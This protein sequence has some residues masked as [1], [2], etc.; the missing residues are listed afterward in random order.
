MSRT[1]STVKVER[2]A[3][4]LRVTMTRPEVHNAFN[5]HLI[6]DLS[7]VFRGIARDADRPDAPRVV[8]YTGDHTVSGFLA[9]T[10][11]GRM[12]NPSESSKAPPATISE[13][14]ESRARSI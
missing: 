9:R 14:T 8:V 1:Y 13:S 4:F 7:D 3:E 11:V 2:D 6:A 10:M 12:K 5:E